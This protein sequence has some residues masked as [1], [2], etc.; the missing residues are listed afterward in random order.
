MAV[1]VIMPRVD[2]TMERG[3]IRAWNRAAGE[4]VRAGETLFVIE[5]DKAAMDIEAPCDGVLGEVLVAPGIEVPVGTVVARI[6]ARGEAVAVAP[7]PGAA[8]PSPTAAP[9]SG[10]FVPVPAAPAQAARVASPPA[11]SASAASAAS[12]RPRATPL[13]RRMARTHGIELAAIAGSGPLGRIG[14]GDVEA[15]LASAAPAAPAA[16]AP[17]VPLAALATRPF[18]LGAMLDLAALDALR[19]RIAPSLPGGRPPGLTAMI[20]RVLRVALARHPSIGR[21]QAAGEAID[22]AL[23]LARDGAMAMPV[24]RGLQAMRV[25]DI[26]RALGDLAAGEPVGWPPPRLAL[27]NAGALGLDEFSEFDPGHAVPLLSVGCMDRGS[28]VARATFSADRATLDPAA[29]ALFLAE[30]RA[31]AAAPETSL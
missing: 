18:R 12:G 7:A 19:A 29:A 1:D 20:L 3:A 2:M 8:A 13:A 21:V 25:P 28:R 24:L 10:A 4:A 6:L 15:F 23:V 5:T 9:V 22:V 31:L 11:A 27:A 17:T 26:A 14:R 16:V 30:L